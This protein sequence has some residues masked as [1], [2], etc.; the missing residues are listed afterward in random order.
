[1]ISDSKG[2]SIRF[3]GARAQKALCL[4]LL[5]AFSS[6]APSVRAQDSDPETRTAAREMATQGAEAFE[7]QD[8]ETALDRFQRA[9]ALFRAPSISVME[10]RTLVKLGRL[11]AALDK[12]ESTRHIVLPPDAPEALH[13][14]V[15]DAAHE[16]AEGFKEGTGGS[17]KAP[18]GEK[19]GVINDGEGPLEN[20]RGPLEEQKTP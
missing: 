7:K 4:A 6:A 19:P 14:A 15:E 5:L 13:R 16:A 10:A 9:S 12:Y 17:G 8:Y 1:M 18:I 2:Q 11:L 3:S 20:G